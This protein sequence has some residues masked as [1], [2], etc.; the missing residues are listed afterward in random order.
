MT[1]R[2]YLSYALIRVADEQRDEALNVGVLVLDP[3][4]RELGVRVTEDLSRVRRALPNVEINH[5]QAYLEGLP[6][7]FR[8]QANDLT[9]ERLT[10]LSAE[11]GNGV[12]LSGVRSI[13]GHQAQSVVDDLFLRYVDIV[14]GA[15]VQTSAE[16]PAIQAATSLRTARAVASKLRDRGFRAGHDY[17]TDA[18]VIG[19]TARQTEVPVW[20][21]LRFSKRL[22]IDS[23]DVRPADERRTVD[24]ARLIASKTDE[25]LR[26]EGHSVAVVVREAEDEHLNQLVR[27]L[28]IEEG[29]IG[30]R[31]PE[32][33]SYSQVDSFVDRLP[34]PQGRLELP[35]GE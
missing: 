5:L 13:A 33:H 12:R 1:T 3:A 22:L 20:F 17:E 8:E 10:K 31:G 24:N 6:D 32:I 34:H 23:M 7:F 35:P 11:W 14:E 19:R 25:V 26:V 9:P 15:P 28:L 29:T 16:F 4:S 21:P 18:R 2:K 27:S 30:E